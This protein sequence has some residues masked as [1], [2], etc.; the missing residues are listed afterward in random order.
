MGKIHVNLFDKNFAHSIQE[1]GFDTAS[2]G[3]EPTKIQWVRDLHNWA[4]VTVFT[5]YYISEDIVDIVE[6]KHKV[7]WLVEPK[8]IHP[9]AYENIIKVEHKFDKIFT[10]DA[11]L[12]KRGSKYVRS[13]VGSI[14]VPLDDQKVYDKTKNVSIIASHK[15]ETEGHK[16][17]HQIVNACPELDAWGSG[18]KRFESKLDPLKDY[19]FSVAIMNS[20]VENYFTEILTDCIAC[21][22]VPIFWGTPNIGDFFNIDGIIEF[23]NFD[24]FSKIKL[25]KQLYQDMLPAIRENFAILSEYRSTDDM[26][27]DLINKEYYGD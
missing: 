24:E 13:I 23:A 7:A 16:F 3:L 19:M 12:L 20:R 14:R 17:R 8:S 2:A 26:I 9:W 4:G 11:D 25:S 22:T 10:H 21:G 1:D 27:G 18:Y 6:S 15:K 5:D